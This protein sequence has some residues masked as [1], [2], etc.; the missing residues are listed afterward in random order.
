MGR[1]YVGKIPLGTEFWV[2]IHRVTQDVKKLL[3]TGLVLPNACVYLGLFDLL[4][5]CLGW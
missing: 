4:P 2:R 1:N 5:L 3:Q